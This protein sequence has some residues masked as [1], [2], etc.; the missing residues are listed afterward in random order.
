VAF[1]RNADKI[2]AL[3]GEGHSRNGVFFEIASKKMTELCEDHRSE[4]VS[5]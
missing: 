2:D 1:L 5:T 4:G 3:K